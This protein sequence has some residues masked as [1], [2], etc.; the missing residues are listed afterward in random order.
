[1]MG[2]VI[3]MKVLQEI[4]EESGVEGD[5]VIWSDSAETVGFCNDG[6]IKNLP[7]RSVSRNMDL[8]MKWKISKAKYGGNIRLKKVAAH[9]DDGTKY[10]DL[11]FEAR[12]N[13]DCDKFAGEKVKEV[14][15][16]RY[17]QTLEKEV[18]VMLWSQEGGITGDVYQWMME[19]GAQETV[20]MRL[21]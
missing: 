8:K 18:Q 19:R 1:M 5:V 15:E 6:V 3:V 4:K 7:S 12:R 11:S 20:M 10:K 17:V 21:K 14:V 2:P 9:Q 16:E 13:I